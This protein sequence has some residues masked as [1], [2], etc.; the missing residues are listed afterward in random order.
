M[1]KSARAIFGRDGERK[2]RRSGAASGLRDQITGEMRR[3]LIG[4]GIRRHLG[5]QV[6]AHH[7]PF[8]FVDAHVPPVALRLQ[9][10]YARPKNSGPAPARP[11]PAGRGAEPDPSSSCWLLPPERAAARAPSRTGK[12]ARKPAG[13]SPDGSWLMP[14]PDLS[15]N[16]TNPEQKSFPVLTFPAGRAGVESAAG[17]MRPAA[18]RERGGLNQSLPAPHPKG[19]VAAFSDA[20]CALGGRR[21]TVGQRAVGAPS[22]A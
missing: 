21:A 7:I 3:E 17:R 6:P 9:H 14:S 20:C 2:R 1:R 4:C 19:G 12:A 16:G 18:R 5:R 11:H 13:R 22:Y 8:P 10:R 15:V